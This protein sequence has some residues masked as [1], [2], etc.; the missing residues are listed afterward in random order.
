[1]RTECEELEVKF[2][3]YFLMVKRFM[4]QK[5]S[6][7][8]LTSSIPRIQHSKVLAEYFFKK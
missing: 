6:D 5:Y 8:F 4:S 3:I 2:S 7:K 1:M